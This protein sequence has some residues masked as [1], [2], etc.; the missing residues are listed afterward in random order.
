MDCD[1][2]YVLVTCHLGLIY[3]LCCMLRFYLK[4]L[5]SFI[6]VV[7][8]RL[9]AGEDFIRSLVQPFAEVEPVG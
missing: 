8:V 6:W 7:D 1:V 5:I 3:P 2:I 9:V 4:L